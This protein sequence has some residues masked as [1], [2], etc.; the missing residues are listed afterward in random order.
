M[1]RYGHGRIISADPRKIIPILPSLAMPLFRFTHTV[2]HPP[3]KRPYFATLTTRWLDCDSASYLSARSNVLSP[4]HSDIIARASPHLR[5]LYSPKP[6]KTL[7]RTGEGGCPRYLFRYIHAHIIRDYKYRDKESEKYYCTHSLPLH[8]FC[9]KLDRP[10]FLL[11]CVFHSLDMSL[12]IVNI[13]LRFLDPAFDKLPR[14]WIAGIS[15][16]PHPL[17]KLRICFGEISLGRPDLA[18]AFSFN[19]SNFPFEC[20]AKKVHS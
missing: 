14:L 7:L 17:G 20:R 1:A 3:A 18:R 11:H 19:L 13:S 6:D 15:E 9:D 5:R 2:R 12:I 8:L 16:V 4:R 10:Y